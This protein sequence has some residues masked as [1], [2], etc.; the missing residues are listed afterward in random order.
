MVLLVCAPLVV[1]LEMNPTDDP[2]F[3]VDAAVEPDVAR[4]FGASPSGTK[5]LSTSPL[6]RPRA[7]AD[8]TNGT[9]AASRKRLPLDGTPSSS[10]SLASSAQFKTPSRS[11][12]TTTTTATSPAFSPGAGRLEAT[13]ALEERARKFEAMYQHQRELADAAYTAQLEAQQALQD[14][15][16]ENVGLM[17][18]LDEAKRF[19]RQLKGELKVG[20][21]RALP[22]HN[23]PFVL[24]CDVRESFARKMQT[25]EDDFDAKLAERDR[26]IVA[27]EDIVHEQGGRLGDV[28][29]FARAKARSQALAHELER[30]HQRATTE[31]DRRWDAEQAL[32]AL[33]VQMRA[34][35]KQR[36]A[37]EASLRECLQKQDE[38]I[39]YLEERIEQLTADEDVAP[40]APPLAERDDACDGVDVSAPPTH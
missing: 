10:A 40:P 30:A 12:H 23:E 36:D 39:D 4:R 16:T 25:L 5:M 15:V 32:D 2:A 22:A 8:I 7:F 29:H 18:R 26:T 19:I 14:K 35:G 13:R 17:S 28:D 9:P 24:L 1:A 3:F 6:P 27:L 33:R 37:D 11:R 20:R 38:Y 34:E 31:S 21:E